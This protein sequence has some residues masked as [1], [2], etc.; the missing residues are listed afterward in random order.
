[1]D[2]YFCPHCGDVMKKWQGSIY[3]CEECED[4]MIDISIFE[5]GEG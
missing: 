2:E 1:M 5:E 4:V 3:E